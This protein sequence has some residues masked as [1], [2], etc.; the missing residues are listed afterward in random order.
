MTPTERNL[1]CA[2]AAHLKADAAAAAFPDRNVDYFDRFHRIAEYLNTQ[3]HP[4]V[5]QGSAVN[6]SRPKRAGPIWLTD[7]GPEHVSTVIERASAL[8]CTLGCVLDPYET[9][10]LLLGIHFHDVGNVFGREH[11]ERRINEVM[12]QISEPLIGANKLEHRMIRDLA[13]VHG[14]EVTVGGEK[15]KDT[16]GQLRYTGTK[17]PRIP[18]LAAILR[19]ADELADDHTRTS[20]FILDGVIPPEAE[21][22]H[23]YAD[24]L[25]QVQIEASEHR[26]DLIFEINEAIAARRIKKDSKEIYLFDE[27][28]ER[29]MKTH[30]ENVYCSRFMRHVI[31]IDHLRVTVKIC[32]NDY[33]LVRDK[34]VYILREQGY[35]TAATSIAKLCP[36]LKCKTGDELIAHIHTLGPGLEGDE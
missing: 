11:H 32:S 25:R 17:H 14:G 35:P 4:N 31:H 6:S 16:I 28:L 3:I 29:T 20:R 34:L 7:H 9:Y 2:L 19:L 12:S 21:V 23:L 27:I 30:R 1:A 5:N 22:Y 18:L 8:S 15:T 26:V 36:D 13:M 33:M 24:R 10:L